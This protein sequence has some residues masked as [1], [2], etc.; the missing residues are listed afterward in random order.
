MSVVR[1]TKTLVRQRNRR[2]RNGMTRMP[3]QVALN[4]MLYDFTWHYGSL[5]ASTA[6]VIS[7]ADISPTIQNST[8]YASLL[9]IFGESKLVSCTVTAGP[10]C[11]TT[12]ISSTIVIGTKLSVNANSH[13]TPPLTSS[14]VENLDR[15]KTWP[16][17]PFQVRALN[18]QMK[19]PRGLEFSLITA[20]APSTQTP[21]AGAPGC[22]YIFGFGASASQ[23]YLDIYV[24]CRHHLRSRV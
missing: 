16:V 18:Y 1:E 21:W 6:G 7:A 10:L 8:E 12:S 19:V 4:E 14:Q 24:R 9:N 5:A 3:A 13:D 20:D 15:K 23:G 11:N 22:V 17:G 2:R